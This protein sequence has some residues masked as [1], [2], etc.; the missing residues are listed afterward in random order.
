MFSLSRQQPAGAQASSGAAAIVSR[1]SEQLC[2][3]IYVRKKEDSHRHNY[4][5]V[6][7]FREFYI[8]EHKG[9]MCA[10]CVWCHLTSITQSFSLLGIII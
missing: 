2:R 10:E 4:I 9:R 6:L 7:C 3:Y 1:V 5:L 8:E